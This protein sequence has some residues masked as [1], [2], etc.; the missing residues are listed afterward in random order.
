MQIPDTNTNVDTQRESKSQV[1][2]RK[3]EHRLLFIDDDKAILEG[4]KFI[5]ESEGFIVDITEDS[6][7][8]LELARKNHY[9]I[10]IIDYILP[11]I[12]GDELA[13]KLLQTDESAELIIISGQ[14]SAE[15]ELQRRGVKVREVF[16]KPLKMETLVDYIWELVSFTHD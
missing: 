2:E 3:S 4:Y 6:E 10:I 15:E 11:G 8:A 7:S 12:R 9:T 13:E 16:M 5:F 1:D 14:L